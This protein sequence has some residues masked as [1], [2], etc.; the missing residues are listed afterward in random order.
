M[1]PSTEVQL[2]QIGGEFSCIQD[3]LK[4]ARDLVPSLPENAKSDGVLKASITTLLEGAIQ[5]AQQNIDALP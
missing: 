5:R 2:K 4:E 3:V 1:D